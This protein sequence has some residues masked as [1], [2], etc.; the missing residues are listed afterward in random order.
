MIGWYGLHDH[1]AAEC[2]INLERRHLDVGGDTRA[3][4]IPQQGMSSGVEEKLAVRGRALITVS[5]DRQEI[6]YVQRALGRNPEARPANGVTVI[7][8]CRRQDRPARD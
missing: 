7:V 5:R 4:S 1:H 3:V 2:K 8:A 6:R